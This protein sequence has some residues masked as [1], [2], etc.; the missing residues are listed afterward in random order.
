ME[1][2]ERTARN[3]GLKRTHTNR[4]EEVL[5]KNRRHAAINKRGHGERNTKQE[6]LKHR[7]HERGK[8]R[9]VLEAR[10]KKHKQWDRKQEAI[11]KRHEEGTY[12]PGTSNKIHKERDTKQGTRR[13]EARS[14]VHEVKK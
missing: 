11:I 2:K 12:N 8:R 7:T 10:H 3:D 6:T 1:G 4:D 5:P 9:M 14:K 13:K